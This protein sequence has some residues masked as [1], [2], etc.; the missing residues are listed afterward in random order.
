MRVR[1]RARALM[2]PSLSP[3]LSLLP[4]SLPLTQALARVL[5][6]LSISPFLSFF[7]A[8]LSLR[9]GIVHCQWQPPPLPPHHAAVVRRRRKVKQLLVAESGGCCAICGYSR[10][11]G[12]LAF[13]HMDREE[14]TL[15]VSMSGITLSIDFLR[16]E[17]HK[18]VLLCSNCHAE[19]EAG[20]SSLPIQ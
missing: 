20:V 18:C 9:R 1:E 3:F 6:S 16:S 11:V 4:S 19:V 12:A 13:H 15:A 14:K 8:S 2:F 10:Y 17:A 7:P 5:V